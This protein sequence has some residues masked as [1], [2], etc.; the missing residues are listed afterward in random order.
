MYYTGE[1]HCERTNPQ[2]VGIDIEGAEAESRGM[3]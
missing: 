1:Y 3:S 2:S